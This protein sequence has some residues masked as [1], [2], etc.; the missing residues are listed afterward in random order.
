MPLL[1][2]QNKDVALASDMVILKITTPNIPD[3]ALTWLTNNPPQGTDST[4]LNYVYRVAGYI[5]YNGIA[6]TEDILVRWLDIANTQDRSNNKG[7]V[8]G[9]LQ[10]Y[11]NCQNDKLA[12]AASSWAVNHGYT[13]STWKG[14]A[15]ARWGQASINLSK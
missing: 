14:P 12:S 15:V 6:N 8:I 3:E 10:T 2:D 4:K 5:I 1:K 7:T 9:L 13:V 11:M